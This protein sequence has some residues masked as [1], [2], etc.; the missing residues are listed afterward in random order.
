MK[1]YEMG[2]LVLTYHG[3]IDSTTSTILFPPTIPNW[4]VKLFTSNKETSIEETEE[5]SYRCTYERLEEYMDTVGTSTEEEQYHYAIEQMI[6]FRYLIPENIVL[7]TTEKEYSVFMNQFIERGT[8]IEEYDDKKKLFDGTDT[9]TLQ[10]I[11]LLLFV[12]QWAKKKYQITDT[13]HTIFECSAKDLP[14]DNVI[15]TLHKINFPIGTV[16]SCPGNSYFFDIA[17]IEVNYVNLP[18]LI[19]YWYELSKVNRLEVQAFLRG[20]KYL[21]D[22]VEEYTGKMISDNMHGYFVTEELLG[23]ERTLEDELLTVLMTLF[24][25]GKYPYFI[26]HMAKSNSIS[27]YNMDYKFIPLTNIHNRKSATSCF[28]ELRLLINQSNHW[29]IDTDGC[30]TTTEIEYTD[31]AEKVVTEDPLK[32]IDLI[33]YLIS[34]KF[35]NRP[36]KNIR[37]VITNEKERR[38]KAYQ[39]YVDTEENMSEPTETITEEEL[40]MFY[41]NFYIEN[42]MDGE[43]NFY[44]WWKQVSHGVEI[45]NK[46]VYRNLSVVSEL[47]SGNYKHIQKANEGV[48]GNKIWNIAMYGIYI[49]TLRCEYIKE[50]EWIRYAALN[51]VKVIHSYPWKQAKRTNRLLEIARDPE[52][53]DGLALILAAASLNIDT[54]EIYPA[55]QYIVKNFTSDLCDDGFYW[56]NYCKTESFYHIQWKLQN[57]LSC[58]V[59]PASIYRLAIITL[60]KI[61]SNRLSEIENDPRNY[62]FCIQLLDNRLFSYNEINPLSEEYCSNNVIDHSSAVKITNYIMMD[63]LVM[64]VKDSID[65]LNQDRI[66]ENW[67]VVMESKNIVDRDNIRSFNEHI[68]NFLS[69]MK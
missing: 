64:Q 10:Y 28:S 67:G 17:Y 18:R 48:I 69:K 6:W 41:A 3:V 7:F 37:A 44:D 63:N 35:V 16:S 13:D 36:L 15:A 61:L 58:N 9:D 57:F 2:M 4:M 5:G 31:T 25:N 56:I 21:P 11:P 27:D 38:T 23:S 42:S 62:M 65:Y 34:E 32:G 66:Y 45:T 12:M 54:Y 39:M 49:F 30:I 47:F 26:K 50:Y 68:A 51:A 20:E 60:R 8:E 46:P 33:E 29:F 59:V 43:N 19:R 24:T 53:T 22:C 55:Y 1:T 40:I 52:N 14:Y